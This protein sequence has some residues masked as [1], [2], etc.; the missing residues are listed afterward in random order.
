LA[1]DDVAFHP[2]VDNQSRGAPT[3]GLGSE[4]PPAHLRR[5]AERDHRLG[6]LL[7]QVPRTLAP[8]VL[9]DDVG[10]HEDGSAGCRESARAPIRTEVPPCVVSLLSIQRGATH[11]VV[12]VVI[13]E[14]AVRT[15]RKGG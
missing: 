13:A 7:R 12:G 4:A 6:R 3:A 1:L 8:A 14:R 15:W 11:W 9:A 2:T 5:G 10:R